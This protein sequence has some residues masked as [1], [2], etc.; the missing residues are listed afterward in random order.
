MKSPIEKD[1]FDL[2][3]DHF[4]IPNREKPAN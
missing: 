2:L 3:P 1:L 4:L